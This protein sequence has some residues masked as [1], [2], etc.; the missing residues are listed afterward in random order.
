M[1]KIDKIIDYVKEN[2]I[3]LLVV[4]AIG[5]IIGMGLCTALAL[6]NGTNHKAYTIMSWPVCI[7]AGTLINYFL[8]SRDK[9][10]CNEYLS[11][12]QDADRNLGYRRIEGTR[13]LEFLFEDRS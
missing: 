7:T 4:F 13:Q 6:L 11:C 2:I 12:K 1:R 10:I 9:R 8:V 5:N 3:V